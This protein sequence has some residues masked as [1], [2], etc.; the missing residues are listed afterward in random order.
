MHSIRR[1]QVAIIGGGVIGTSIAYHLAKMGVRDLILIE[2]E[3]ILGMGSTGKSVGGIRQQFSQEVNIRLTQESLKAIKAF[4]DE[5]EVELDFSQNGYLFLATNEAEIEA[6]KN[7][8][9]F[10]KKFGVEVYRLSPK[11]IHGIVPGINC[12]DVLGATF[13][14][15]D[16]YVD[17]YGLVYGYSKQALR[18]GARIFYQTEAI[19]LE[20]SLSKIKGILT[21]KGF[22]EAPIV[23][24]AAG[25]YAGQIGEM[26]NLK[27]PVKPLKRQVFVTGQVNSI[28]KKAPMVI[29]Y[30]PPFYFRPESGGLLLSLAEKDEVSNFDTTVSWDHLEELAKRTLERLP[31][32]E[33]IEIIRG[34]AGLRTLSPDQNAIVGEIST[35]SGFFCAIAFSGH[36][37]MHAP[38]IGKLVAEMIIEGKTLTMDISDLSPERFNLENSKNLRKVESCVI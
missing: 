13:S 27:L 23:V 9:D 20:S 5:M 4:H 3:V 11:E 28:L 1:A 31:F 8:S 38:A 7:N 12:R 2:K 6:F 33:E 17:P 24:N 32:L 21:N 14:P 26:L 22:I 25:P 35:G 19:G 36:G 18:R 30:T 34:W 15:Q 16:G 10:Q 29:S 37:V